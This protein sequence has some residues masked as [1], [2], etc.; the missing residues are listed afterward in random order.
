M[1]RTTYA[2]LGVNTS[3]NTNE[4][5]DHAKHTSIVQGKRASFHFISL[6][7]LMN[8]VAGPF[9]MC[10][11]FRYFFSLVRISEFLYASFSSTTCV[12]CTHL[13]K[14]QRDRSN[15]RRSRITENLMSAAALIQIDAVFHSHAI[16][17]IRFHICTRESSDF[18][19]WAVSLCLCSV[20]K[21][22]VLHEFLPFHS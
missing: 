5:N 13:L 18:R 15:K 19:L 16:C 2:G 12:R 14:S 7:R 6:N 8:P 3:Q 1:I 17:N 20:E 11:S 10:H 22:L 9:E 4:A 21:Q